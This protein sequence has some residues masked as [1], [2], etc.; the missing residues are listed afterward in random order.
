MKAI[1]RESEFSSTN[2]IGHKEIS[3]W[4]KEFG[5][6]L[7]L[8]VGEELIDVLSGSY[9]AFLGGITYREKT[10]Y[11]NFVRNAKKFLYLSLIHI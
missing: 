9:Y 7:P 8:I 11:A 4:P 2:A 6:Y 10:D 3:L 1:G 5:A